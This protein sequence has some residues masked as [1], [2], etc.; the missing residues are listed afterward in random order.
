MKHHLKD[1]STDAVVIGLVLV[2]IVFFVAYEL[3]PP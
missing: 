1:K 2:I 3:Q